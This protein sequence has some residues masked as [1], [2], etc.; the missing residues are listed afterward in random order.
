MLIGLD[1]GTSALRAYLLDGD[2]KVVDSAAAPLGILKVPQGDFDGAFEQ[3]AGGWLGVHADAAV[4]A[5]GMIGSRQG[6][7]E[8]PYVSCPAGL[9]ELAG[10]LAAVQT[11]R[12]RTVHLVPGVARIDADGVPDVMR[13]EETMIFG[14]ANAVVG[15]AGHY[16]LP[17]THSKWARLEGGRIAWF[18]TFMTG[19]LFAVLR[20][21]SILGRLM[22]G[23]AHDAEAFQEGVRHALAQPAGRGGLLRRLF[24]VRTLGLFDRLPASGLHSYLSGLLIGTEALEARACIGSTAGAP[25]ATATLLGSAELVALYGEAL[26]TAGFACVQLD[27]SAAARG[28]HRIASAAGISPSAAVA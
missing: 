20:S 16:V 10:G 6:W 26:A 14:A 18:A 21:H 19:E 7:R 3:I 11:R 28:L 23:E 8:V 2:G 24:S 22:Q 5:C 12:G 17:G 15:K 1:W 13:G 9:A 27:E 25:S 4:I